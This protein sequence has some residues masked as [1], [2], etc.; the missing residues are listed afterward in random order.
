MKVAPCREIKPKKSGGFTLIEFGIVVAL[1]AIAVVGIYSFYQARKNSSGVSETA[2]ELVMIGARAQKLYSDQPSFTGVTAA[3]LINNGIVPANMVSGTTI[4]TKWN[5]TVAVGAG[6]LNTAG[7]ALSLT[8]PV[9]PKS[10]SDFVQEAAAGSAKVT[11]GGQVVKDI[12]SGV[13]NLVIGTLGT[14][15]SGNGNVNVALLIGR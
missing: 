3:V 7:D 4:R 10:C 15:C 5:T 1:I 11:V 14:A 6:T 8:V 2:Q 12:V 13:D 9:Q